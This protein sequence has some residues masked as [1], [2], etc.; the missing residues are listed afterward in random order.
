MSAI[1]F[2]LTFSIILATLIWSILYFQYLL[3]KNNKPAPSAQ[4]RIL[5]LQLDDLK[6]ATGMPN[7]SAPKQEGTD[8]LNDKWTVTLA[9]LVVLLLLIYFSI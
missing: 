6:E 1:F 2:L 3:T 7:A 8:W 4:P 5:V 9:F